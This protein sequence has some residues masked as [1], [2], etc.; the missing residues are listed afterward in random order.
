MSIPFSLWVALDVFFVLIAT[1][2]VVYGEVIK[3][4]LM[5]SLINVSN[6]ELFIAETKFTHLSKNQL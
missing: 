5:S 3:Y 2:L 6:G 1:A 4:I